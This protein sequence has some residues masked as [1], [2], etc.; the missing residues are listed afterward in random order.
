MVK[1]RGSLWAVAVLTA[2]GP[3]GPQRDSLMR[4]HG[5]A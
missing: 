3:G 2:A 1:G 5:S 4:T